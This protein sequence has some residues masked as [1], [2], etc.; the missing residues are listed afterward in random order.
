MTLMYLSRGRVCA[1]IERSL[2]AQLA[3]HQFRAIIAPKG[4]VERPIDVVVKSLGPASLPGGAAFAPGAFDKAT[5]SITFTRA[6]ARPVFADLD[7]ETLNVSPAAVERVLTP[8]TRALLPV[9]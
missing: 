3:P 4:E 5:N 1:P 6:G 9:H 2:A 8:R 7:P